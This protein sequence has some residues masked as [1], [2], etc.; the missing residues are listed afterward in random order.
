MAEG[1]TM[2]AKSLDQ[3][4]RARLRAA[5]VRYRE[6]VARSS[7]G[8]QLTAEEYGEVE[9]ALKELDVPASAWAKDTSAA[10]ELATITASHATASAELSA[11]TGTAGEVRAEIESLETRAREMR[12]ALADRRIKLESAVVRASQRQSTLYAESWLV[13]MGEDEAFV[14]LERAIDDKA[15]AASAKRPV[16]IR[17]EGM[18][19]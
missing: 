5:L 7:R 19:R 4:R 15:A 6:L 1:A 12:R 16:A 8:E 10:R 13:L 17:P 9:V 3:F 11:L 14:A 2:A 18:I